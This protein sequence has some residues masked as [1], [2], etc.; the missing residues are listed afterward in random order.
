MTTSTETQL[1]AGS[2]A[3]QSSDVYLYVQEGGSSTEIYVHAF[4]SEEQANA[5]RKSCAE[6]AYRTSE[7]IKAPASLVDH[8]AFME[9]V[10]GLLSASLSVNYP[11][12]A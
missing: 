11:E 4:D 5:G 12:E 9:V 3:V 1:P 2:S 10:Q 6:A 8:P 7:I